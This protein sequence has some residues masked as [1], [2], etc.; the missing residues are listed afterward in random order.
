ML[1]CERLLLEPLRVA[2]AELLF[3]LL[4]DEAAYM[5]VPQEPPTLES[6][7]ERYALLESRASPNGDQ[8]WL[9]W[10]LHRKTADEYVGLVQATVHADR[11]VQLAYQLF[12]PCWGRGYATEAC[13]RVLQLLFGPYRVTQVLA[14][15][16]T[17]NR[18][19]IRLLERLGFERASCQPAADHF[20]GRTSDEY[21][22]RLL[23]PS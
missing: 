17:R 1:E 11:T 18:A 21:T 19:S 23:R 13:R 10:A 4:Q 8:V 7:R 5:F 12:P 22:Y 6:L 16:D 14:E 2:H 20:K 9:N 3:E 15:V